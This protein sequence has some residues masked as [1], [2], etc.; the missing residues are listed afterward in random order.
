[1]P[2]GDLLPSRWASRLERLAAVTSRDEDRLMNF[3]VKPDVYGRYYKVLR[4]RFLLI[5]ERKVQ[6]QEGIINWLA[7][8]AVGM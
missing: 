4:D 3:I 2:R 8:G 6:R 1:M 5:V 7:E